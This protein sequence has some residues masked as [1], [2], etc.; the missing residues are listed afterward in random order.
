MSRISTQSALAATFLVAACN[1]APKTTTASAPASA[2]AVAAPPA[3]AAEAEPE[4]TEEE[5]DLTPARKAAAI[6]NKIEEAPDNAD[7]ILEAEGLDRER[8]IAQLW[9]IAEDDD[10]SEEYG[11]LYT[12]KG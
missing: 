9:E 1:E 12:P 5:I 8:F 3:S 11:R 6:A 4:E 7:A 10:L 2:V